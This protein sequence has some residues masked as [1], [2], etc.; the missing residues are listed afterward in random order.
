L[1][2][3]GLLL[4][5]QTLVLILPALFLQ[6]SWKTLGGFT[7]MTLLLIMASLGIG[8]MD[9]FWGLINL[10]RESAIGHGLPTNNPQEMVNW[11]MVGI[12]LSS[13]LGLKIGWGIALTGLAL[14]VLA[15]L[16]LWRRPIPPSSPQ[17][18][19]ALLGTMAATCAATWHSHPHMMTFLVPP[20]LY[21]LYQRRLPAVLLDLWLFLMPALLLT[22][23]ALDL[24]GKFRIIPGLPPDA[25]AATSLIL[26]V[27]GLG[28]NLSFLFWVVRTIQ[29]LR[30]ENGLAIA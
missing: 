22:G 5:P 9:A 28:L 23:L 14:T 11:R 13:L 19:V 15:A 7:A 6:G 10:W 2:L 21:L 3:A 29:R 17:F 18:G 8:G 4:K 26:A 24:L 1:W 30:A 25:L 27:G 20:L 16:S 12:R